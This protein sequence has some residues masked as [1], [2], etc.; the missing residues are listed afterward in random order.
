M[1]LPP[2]ALLDERYI[3]EAT[4]GRGGF[5]TVYAARHAVLGTEHAVKVLDA[6]QDRDSRGRLLREGRIQARL[7]HPNVVRVTDV[8]ELNDG[9]GYI[10]PI[11]GTAKWMKLSRR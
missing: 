6:G 5:A 8:V 11:T 4:L 7:A 1:N 3:V 10:D 2:G 9:R